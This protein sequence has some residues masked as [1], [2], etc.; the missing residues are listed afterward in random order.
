MLHFLIGI[1]AGSEI[2]ASISVQNYITFLLTIFMIF[3]IVFELPVISVLLTQMRLLKVEWM[4]KGRR[5]SYH[6]HLYRGGSYHAAGYRVSD[7][8]G[9]PHGGTV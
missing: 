7:H 3:G 1:S 2:T 6:R 5:V 4:K 9:H 8:G